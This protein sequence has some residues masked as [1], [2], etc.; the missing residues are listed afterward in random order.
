MRS[1][2][3]ATALKDTHCQIFPVTVLCSDGRPYLG[4]A[5]EQYDVE[6]DAETKENTARVC[7]YDGSTVIHS[8]ISEDGQ[9][10]FRHCH[11]RP[12]IPTFASPKRWQ[13]A[14][15]SI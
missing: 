6:K 12:H 8:G 2:S 9:H 11:L 14:S 5:T 1:G 4:F 10:H 3:W 15:D 7:L 13:P